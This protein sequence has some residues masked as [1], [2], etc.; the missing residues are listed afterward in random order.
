MD[1]IAIMR[2]LSKDFY[3]RSA[4]D[5]VTDF[6]GK[7]LVHQTPQGRISGIVYDVEAYPAFSDEVHHGN[8]K[9]PR[10]EVMW[11]E[12]GYAYVYVIYGVWHQLAAV[13]NEEDIPDVVFIRGVTPFEGIELMKQQWDRERNEKDLA[14][15]PGKLCK[16]FM[17]TKERYGTD[18]TGDELFFEDR[19]IKI[20]K[21]KI[22]T[23]KR[24][25][26]DSKYKGHDA[27]L[28]YFIKPELIPLA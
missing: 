26:I 14:N 1:H 21:D 23:T 28:R 20:P 6:L 12:G 2:R 11:G 7:V 3:L 4:L 16:S 22:Q 5:C 24:I 17:I 27:P 19:G 13:V 9:T 25:G 18:L 15:S 10:T 8:K